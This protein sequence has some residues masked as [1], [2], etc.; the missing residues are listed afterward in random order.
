MLRFGL[1]WDGLG[2]MGSGESFGLAF[3]TSVN[4]PMVSLVVVGS[5]SCRAIS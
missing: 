2:W 3:A 1:G 4:A 5:T